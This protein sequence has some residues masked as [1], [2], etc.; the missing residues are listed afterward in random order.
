MKLFD[1]LLLMHKPEW[2][3]LIYL[4]GL[5]SALPVAYFDSDAA[6]G[7]QIIYTALAAMWVFARLTRIGW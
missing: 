1:R 3:G 4:L 6:T 2:V 7:L 5:C